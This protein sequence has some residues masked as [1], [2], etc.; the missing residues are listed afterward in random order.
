MPQGVTDAVALF[1]AL[2]RHLDRSVHVMHNS[3]DR[4]ELCGGA[5]ETQNPLVPYEFYPGVQLHLHC[6]NSPA[7][8]SWTRERAEADPAYARY[9]SLITMGHEVAC[10][11]CSSS[12]RLSPKAIGMGAGHWEV[13]CR[14]CHRHRPLLSA[15]RG[16]REREL[17]DTLSGLA[18]E[19]RLSANPAGILTRVEHLAIEADSLFAG[20]T[21]SCGGRFSVAA[22]PRCSRCNEVI[23]DSP[24]HFTL[25]TSAPGSA[26]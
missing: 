4:C 11:A 15:Y 6:L 26:A 20:E 10:P 8:V 18:L 22:R 25:V 23:L 19:F 12:E 17:Y 9:L 16:S 3:P 5:A 1:H 2:E 14:G 21:C 7:G 24:F 13:N